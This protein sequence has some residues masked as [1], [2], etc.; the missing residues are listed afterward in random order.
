MYIYIHMGSGFRMQAWKR[1]R[2]RSRRRCVDATVAVCALKPIYLQQHM[3]IYIYMYKQKYIYIYIHIYIYVLYVSTNY[4]Y[5]YLYKDINK[6]IY[7]VQALGN[8]PG[9]GEARGAR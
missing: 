7:R 5:E 3:Y 4:I 1:R 9:S 6:H 8:E 2:V